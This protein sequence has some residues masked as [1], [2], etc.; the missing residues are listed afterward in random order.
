MKRVIAFAL[1]LICVLCAGNAFAY[2]KEAVGAENT[3]QEIRDYL[4]GSRWSEW[5]ITGW[6][7]AGSYNE[8]GK[9]AGPS[10][11][12]AVK[13]GRANDLLAF[14]FEDGHYAYAWHNA[15]ALPQVKEPIELTMSGD[16]G[17]APKFRS[18]YVVNN[19]T[20][21]SNCKWV[22]DENGT[23][24]L[25][26]ML[27]YYDPTLM[28]MDTSRAGRIYMQN[29]G[30]TERDMEAT[31]YGEYQRDLRYFS[32]AAFPR[33]IEDA[34]EKLS[35]PP[36]IPTS[37]FTDLTA[38]KVKFSGGKKYAVYTGPGEDYVRS[39]NG[40]GSVSTTDWI[41]VFGEEDGWI[42]IQYDISS[43][44][45]RIGYITADALP[46]KASV[47][48]LD[49]RNAGEAYAVENTEVTDDPLGSQG[50]IAQL[51]VGDRFMWLGTMGEWAYIEF[52]Q[53]GEKLR[54]FVKADMISMVT[55]EN[56][57]RGSQDT[58]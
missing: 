34:R 52:Q 23:W 21:E 56:K 13:Q 41:Q 28:F 35:N 47:K 53:N 31:I 15:A 14:Y 16:S 5:E 18:M 55:V 45:Y 10:A 19:E 20:L 49:L 29:K 6:V 2:S 7:H 4:A 44:R 58:T 12:V 26:E 3:P 22:Q 1:M 25:H 17:G 8:N 42:M 46:K 36:E 43:E 48:E 9:D 38:E 51:R 32:Y 27:V 40:K 39:G 50:A 30:W 24:N 57:E 37:Y 33:T 54:G 11:F